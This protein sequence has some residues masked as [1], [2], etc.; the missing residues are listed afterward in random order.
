[1]NDV[2][3]AALCI[4]T[5]LFISSG[6]MGRRKR[7]EIPLNLVELEESNYHILV[8]STIFAGEVCRW[9][10]DTGASKSVFDASLSSFY[11]ELEM[12]VPEIQSAGIGEGLVKTGIGIIPDIDFEAFQLSDFPVAL[13][14]FSQINKLYK[15]YAHVQIQGLLGSDF[16]LEH[17]AIINYRTMKM[18]LLV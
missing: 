5:D 13:I 7:Y 3:S 11:K 17:K 1:M 14:D 4:L 16:L 6:P 18:S 9:V 8:N 2:Q 10:V 15:R 12:D